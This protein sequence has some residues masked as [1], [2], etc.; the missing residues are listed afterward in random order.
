M[1]HRTR[2]R[3]TIWA[4][5]SSR[6]GRQVQNARASPNEGP[7]KTQT[8]TMP[9][10]R[11][12]KGMLCYRPPGSS[13]RRAPRWPRPHNCRNRALTDARLDALYEAGCDDATFST[14]GELT[15]GEFDRDAPSLLEAVLSA[16][17]AVESFSDGAFGE[18]LHIDPDDL[19]WAS[20]IAQRTGRSRQ[21]IDM[22]VRGQRGPV[23]SQLPSRTPPGTLCGAGRRSKPGSLPTKDVPP[24]TSGRR[25]LEPST[26]PFRPATACAGQRKPWPRSAGP[27]AS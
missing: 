15:F 25:C 22:L 2:C 4:V 26:A 12:T 16:I 17:A 5:T 14:R 10:A 6:G 13:L 9:K 21:S 7:E 8:T 24:T 18:V 20:E 3:P 27:C 1:S 11:G 19:V 23:T